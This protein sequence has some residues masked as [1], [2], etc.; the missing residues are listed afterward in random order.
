MWRSDDK[1]KG[2]SRLKDLGVE[3]KIILKLIF[4]MYDGRGFEL[5]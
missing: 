5:E 3:E 2:R 4:K 1:G